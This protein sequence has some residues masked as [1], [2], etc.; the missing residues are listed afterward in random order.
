[1]FGLPSETVIIH[2]TVT[3]YDKQPAGKYCSLYPAPVSIPVLLPVRF[4]KIQIFFCITQREQCS[5]E[6]FLW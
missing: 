3:D 2:L 4:S 5:N 1:V 6:W